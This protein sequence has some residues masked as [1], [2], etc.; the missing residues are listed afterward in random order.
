MLEHPKDRYYTTNYVW[1]K[2]DRSKSQATVGV[3]LELMEELDE[4]L[5]ID[6][7]LVDDEVEMDNECLYLHVLGDVYGVAA[8]LTG[9][10]LQVNRELMEQIESLLINPYKQWLFVMEY[11]EPDEIEMLLNSDSFQDYL[12]SL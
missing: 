8:P 12:D 9:R 1:A 6:L 7:P 2:L 5:S 11:D 3:T 4:V 10:V